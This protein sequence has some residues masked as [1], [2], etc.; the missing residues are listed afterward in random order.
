MPESF[1]YG[2][3]AVIEGVLIVGRS[4][5]SLAV[6]RPDGGIWT[7]RLSMSPLIRG[8]LG[9]TPLVRGVVV[10]L[11]TLALGI[12]ALNRSAEIAM[13]AEDAPVDEAEDLP[14]PGRVERSAIIGSMLAAVALGVGVFFLLPLL[15]ARALDRVI[16]SSL[17]SN[18]L[19]GMIRLV[20][21]VSYIWLI[22]R[23]GDIKRVFAYHGAEHMTIHAHE[24]GVPLEPDRI[25][26]FPKA[27]PRCGT[28]FLITVVVVS[29]LVFSLVGRPALW[30]AALSRIGLVPVIAAISYELIRFAGTHP[31][32]PLARLLS[33]PGLAFQAMTTRVPDDDQIEVA[34]EAMSK[35]LAADAGP[36]VDTDA[37]SS[38][39][40]VTPPDD[41]PRG[42]AT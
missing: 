41:T 8:R 17:V 21:L 35:A 36:I 39:N 25:R 5:A 32:N 38:P 30:L 1:T 37:A 24:H 23:L 42:D 9:R 34:V 31:G 33:L 19:E 7:G 13:V 2:G 3:Q 12:R 4:G 16:E 15:G 27:H 10:L 18:L 11:G 14:T 22:G 29:I 28:A 6:R 20:M 40:G 26:A